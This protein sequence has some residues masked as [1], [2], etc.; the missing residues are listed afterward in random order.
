MQKSDERTDACVPS[1]ENDRAQRAEDS[2]SKGE[3]IDGDDRIR[4]IVTSDLELDW[5]SEDDD[6][7]SEES[8]SDG[9]AE[10]APSPGRDCLRCE[11]LETKCEGASLSFRWDLTS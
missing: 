11:T 4:D 6:S 3:E 8:D 9:D 7:D 10:Q 1:Q 2:E 5:G